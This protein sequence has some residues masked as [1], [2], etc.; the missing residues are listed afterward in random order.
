MIECYY[1]PDPYSLLG[2]WLRNGTRHVPGDP[3]VPATVMVPNWDMGQ[4]LQMQAARRTGIA[5]NMETV[6]PWTWLNRQY[7]RLH[8]ASKV[9]GSEKSRLHWM[10][11]TILSEEDRE[12]EWDQLNQWARRIALRSGNR[13]GALDQA[14]WDIA[15]KAADVFDQYA[16]YRPDWLLQW[17][18]RRVPDDDRLV[19]RDRRSMPVNDRCPHDD[20]KLASDRDRHM[21]ADK[22]LVPEGDRFVPH[23]NR[24]REIPPVKG[25]AIWQAAL[26]KKLVTKW[27]DLPRRADLLFDLLAALREDRLPPGPENDAGIHVYAVTSMP[28]P[29]MK[30][31]VRLARKAPVFWYGLRR[32]VAEGSV[33][34]E[35]ASYTDKIDQLLAVMAKAEGVDLSVHKDP[36]AQTAGSR[37]ASGQME[38]NLAQSHPPDE[39]QNTPPDEKQDKSP[40]SPVEKSPGFDPAA[41][42][43]SSVHHA[44]KGPAN[45]KRMQQALQEG[46]E[47][48]LDPNDHDSLAIHVCHSP[49]REVEV[50]RDRLLHLFDTTDLRAGDVAIVTPDPETYQPFIEE[51]FGEE[52]D[53]HRKIAVHVGGV[54]RNPEYVGADLFLQGLSFIGSRFKAPDVLDWLEAG[55]ILGETADRSGQR[56]TLHQWIIRQHIRWGI[57]KEQLHRD[58]IPL[59][60]RHTW[61]H[62]VDR[63]LLSWLTA[64]GEQVAIGDLLSGSTVAGSDSGEL[65]GRLA[66]VIS[67]LANLQ[68]E[69]QSPR[70]IPDWIPVLERFLNTAFIPS[71]DEKAS[72]RMIRQTLADLQV[73]A[74][75]LKISQ[76]IDLAVVKRY[77]NTQLEQTGLGRA[78]Q[79]GKVTFTGMVALH[80][81]PYRAVAVLGLNDGNLPARTP[82]PSFDLIPVYPRMG[83]RSRRDAERQLF[84]DYLLTPDRMLHLSYTGRRQRDNNRLAPS[85]MLTMLEDYLLSTVSPGQNQQVQKLTQEH[86]LQPFNTRYFRYKSSDDPRWFSYADRYA[87]LAKSLARPPETRKP[88]FEDISVLGDADLADGTDSNTDAARA[89]DADMKADAGVKTGA[90]RADLIPG[91][92]QPAGGPAGSSSYISHLPEAGLRD[93]RSFYRRPVKHLLR[94]TPGLALDETEIPS[95]YTEPF[96]LDSLDSWKIRNEVLTAWANTGELVVAELEERLYREGRLAEGV[97]GRR[98]FAEL[99]RQLKSN[100]DHI[101]EEWD[102]QAGFRTVEIDALIPVEHPSIAAE[103]PGIPAQSA[104]APTEQPGIP[105]DQPGTPVERSDFSI[106]RPANPTEQPAMPDDDNR[107]QIRLSGQYPFVNDNT[108][109]IIESGKGKKTGKIPLYK[110][111]RC[112][113]THVALNL[114][115]RLTSRILF[116]DNAELSLPAMEPDEAMAIMQQVIRGFLIGQQG[117][118]PFFPANAL[119]YLNKTRGSKKTPPLSPEK[120]MEELIQQNPEDYF[121]DFAPEPISELDTVWV[122]EA[123]GDTHPLSQPAFLS[124]TVPFVDKMMQLYERAE[125]S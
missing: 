100:I 76:E 13:P 117:P 59:S 91:T 33:F 58:N 95:E 31:L 23:E 87:R 85:V 60:G 14:R 25:D 101:E 49:R 112:Y 75:E 83:D 45:L 103:L 53:T 93:L 64:E 124:F 17:S 52:D 3:L 11:F 43:K 26:W 73:M 66:A 79:A 8:T 113:L 29:V 114:K 4:W 62:G 12:A 94:Q 68:E 97:T 77:L 63:L 99:L 48:T 55:P 123:F 119:E 57:D 38:L 18:G 122:R 9:Q 19:F 24:Q 32:D 84:V 41:P 69:A 47:I 88:I 86:A 74:A 2:H 40:G 115:H 1:S 10:I 116:A 89:D 56:G 35:P 121:G 16:V 34:W 96:R 51:V 70:T 22:H 36:P 92:D 90:G 82:V 50:L 98:Q 102:S 72:T 71:D 21:P 7:E 37:A 104:A 107:M 61:R 111:V 110:R 42:P 28:V 5:A 120:A 109:W 78:W 46:G 39:T 81:F 44:G 6:L 20:D 67:A 80:Q 30:V 27:P 125:G 118:L 105:A 65:L 108:C 54:R 106:E 15:G